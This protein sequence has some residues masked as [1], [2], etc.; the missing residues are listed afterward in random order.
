M[1]SWLQATSS[2]TT[3]VIIGCRNVMAFRE[4]HHLLKNRCPV[5]KP[6]STAAKDF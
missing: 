1:A 5:C 6:P 4:T 2:K 3:W